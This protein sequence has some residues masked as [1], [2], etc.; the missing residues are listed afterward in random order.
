[1]AV[2]RLVLR[3]IVLSSLQPAFVSSP[4]GAKRKKGMTSTATAG[5]F[6]VTALLAQQSIDTASQ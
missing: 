3:R 5:V 2:K 6:V 4:V 1:M